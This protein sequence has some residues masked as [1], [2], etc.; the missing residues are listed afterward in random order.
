LTPNADLLDLADTVVALVREDRVEGLADGRV[1]LRLWDF[2]CAA[3]PHSLAVAE[4]R[5]ERAL[6]RAGTEGEA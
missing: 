1:P 5:L 4:V 2:F 3:S 6:A